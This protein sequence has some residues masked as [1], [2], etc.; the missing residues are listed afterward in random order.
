MQL[1]KPDEIIEINIFDKNEALFGFETDKLLC[2]VVF[3]A[4]TL[5]NMHITNVGT[6][7]KTKRTKLVTECSGTTQAQQAGSNVEIICGF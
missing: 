4:S 2:G 5:L 1:S 6:L 7:E 3:P